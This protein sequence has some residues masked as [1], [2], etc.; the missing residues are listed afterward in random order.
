MELITLKDVHKTYHVG[1]IDVPVLKAA[2]P[3][4][5]EPPFKA[6]QLTVL[7][8]FVALG[9][10]SVLRNRGHAGVAEGADGGVSV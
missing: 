6:V 4:Q 8:V 2:A 10:F 1:E 3:T 5:T 7:L 9:L